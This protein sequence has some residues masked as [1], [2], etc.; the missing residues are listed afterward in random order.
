MLPSITLFLLPLLLLSPSSSTTTPASNSTTTPGLNYT[1]KLTK[2]PLLPSFDPLRPGLEAHLPPTLYNYTKWSPGWLPLS[3]K[4]LAQHENHTASTIE[5]YNVHY[6]DCA[7]PWILCRH[8]ADPL[9]LPSYFATF[10]RIPVRAR[11]HV[12]GAISLPHKSQNSAYNAHG[13]IAF[14]NWR[15]PKKPGP[16]S[17]NVNVFV[18]ETGHSLDNS[19]FKM[20]ETQLSRSGAWARVYKRDTHV[21]DGYAAKNV[22]E[23]VAQSTVV[24]AYDVNVPGGFR[25][26]EKGWEGIRGQVGLVRRMQRDAGD[27]L[28]PGG[29]CTQ[30]L[31]NSEPVRVEGRRKVGRRGEGDEGRPDVSLAEGLGVITQKE[32]NTKSGCTH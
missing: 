23:D 21:P 10:G 22:G 19:A 16:L 20:G 26:L 31:V 15:D 13:T 9:P 29:M 1:A 2:P 12:R 32:F 4:T 3:C 17:A 8:I 28:V 30:R 27:V 18:H 11:S 7:S 25:G 6:A 5:V 14:S 24:A